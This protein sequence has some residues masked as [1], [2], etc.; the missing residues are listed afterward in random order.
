MVCFL[1][2]GQP[3]LLWLPIRLRARFII[4]G[5]PLLEKSLS[6]NPREP[7]A[8]LYFVQLAR[9]YINARNYEKALEWLS[10]A[11]RRKPDFPHAHHVLAICLGHLGRIEEARAAATECERLHP[12]FIEKRAQWNIYVDPA[13]NEH[14][15]D[16]LRKAGLLE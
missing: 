10:E 15:L 4:E 16:G 1:T 9:A 11:I 14:L 3:H 7:R 8:H 5:I 2:S 12:G 13:A 6:L